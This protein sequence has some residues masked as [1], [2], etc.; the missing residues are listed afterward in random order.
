[1][2]GLAST[3]WRLADDAAC[4]AKNIL[5]TSVWNQIFEKSVNMK[6]IFLWQGL[7]RETRTHCFLAQH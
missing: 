7:E 5:S 4:H 1:M 2:L 3:L 6:W